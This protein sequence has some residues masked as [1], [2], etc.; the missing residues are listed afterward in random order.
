MR[1]ILY[2][3]DRCGREW[4]KNDKDAP[5][6]WTIGV[7]C[8]AGEGL[9]PFTTVREP[10]AYKNQQWCRPCMDRDNIINIKPPE[11][12]APPPLTFEELIREIIAEEV[13]TQINQGA[14]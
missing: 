12:D 13:T 7:I 1:T 10:S 3:C 9:P 8:K 4:N 5:Q 6:L 2:K 11:P 14:S